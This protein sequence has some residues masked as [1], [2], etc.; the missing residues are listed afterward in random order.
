MSVAE[1]EAAL[2]EIE[3]TLDISGVTE[4]NASTLFIKADQDI[5]DKEVVKEVQ[6]REE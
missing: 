3:N 6:E 2:D 5:T 4:Q 1:Y